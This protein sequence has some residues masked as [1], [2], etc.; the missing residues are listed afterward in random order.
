LKGQG[1]KKA[2]AEAGRKVADNR[3]SDFKFCLFFSGYGALA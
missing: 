3:K 1:K 2:P